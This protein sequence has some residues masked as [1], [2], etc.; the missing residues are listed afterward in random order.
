MFILEKIASATEATKTAN[1][2]ILVS[3]GTTGGTIYKHNVG[4]SGEFYGGISGAEAFVELIINP[5]NKQV[6]SFNTLD[7][8]MEVIDIN[9][10][11]V[12]TDDTTYPW[13]PIFET[14]KQ[15]VFSNSY[16]TSTVDVVYGQNIKKIGKVWRMQVPLFAD[17]K[18]GT[19]ST[20]YVDTYLRVKIIFDSST[21]NRLRLHDITTYYAP[22]KV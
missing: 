14:I 19:R 2:Y 1:D 7:F 20:R 4:P 3:D 22:V 16:Q 6:C 9:D 17:T 12:S 8:R 10:E 5:E 11:E 13:K 18:V 21:A 15:V